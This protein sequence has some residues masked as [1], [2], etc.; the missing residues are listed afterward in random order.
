MPYPFWD[1]GLGYGPLMAFIAVIHVFVSH[2]AIGGGLY[3]VVAERAA[4]KANDGR[5]SSSSRSCRKFFVL[6]TVVF[7]ALTGVGDLVH[8]RAARTRRPP[9]R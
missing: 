4:R 6:M 8:H 2:F 7:G 5:A 3:L 1:A 9:R